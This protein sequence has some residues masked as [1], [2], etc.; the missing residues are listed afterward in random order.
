MSFHALVSSWSG[1]STIS[2]KMVPF[3]AELLA[4]IPNLLAFIPNLLI[5][6][7]KLSADESQFSDCIALILS[8]SLHALSQA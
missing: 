3:K 5:Y 1:N 7:T 6:E 8:N 2:L 4:F